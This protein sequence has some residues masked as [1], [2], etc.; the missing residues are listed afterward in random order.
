MSERGVAAVPWVLSADDEGGL[1]AAARA[2]RDHVAARAELEPADVGW[3]LACARERLA[4]RAV[5]VGADRETLL[6]GLDA[7]ARGAPTRNVARGTAGPADRVAFVFPGQGSQ[8]PGMALDLWAAAPAFGESMRACEAALAPYV[9][10]RLEDVLRAP[11]GAPLW[12]RS[13]VVQPAL[14][15]VMVSLAAL[16]RS[17]GVRPAAVVGHSLGEISAACAAGI[18]SVQDAARVAALTSRALHELGGDDGM[19][20]VDLA[21]EPLRERIAQIGGRLTPAAFNGP[22]A[23]VVAG[24]PGALDRLLAECDADGV[25]ARRIRVDGASSAAHTSRIEAIRERLADELA[26]IA[27]RPSGIAF[28]SAV[29]GEPIDYAELGPEYWYRSLRQPVRFREATSAAVRD[30]VTTFVEASPHPVL[31]LAVEGTIEAA[32]PAGDDR[33]VA[34]TGS[35][36]R[37]GGLERFLGSLGEAYAGGVDV[38]WAPAFA[39]AQPRRVQLPALPARAD[40][41]PAAAGAAATT[42]GRGAAGDALAGPRAA[43]RGALLALVREHAAAVL[44]LD[45]PAAV[46]PRRAFRELGMESLQAVELRNRL[47]QVTGL[48]LASTLAY[49]HPTPAAVAERLAALLSGEERAARATVPAQ[50]HHDEPIALVGM[51]CR[52]PRGVESAQDLW[53]L[54]AAGADAIGPFPTDR[55]WDLERLYDPD[56]DAPGTSYV[57]AGGF[58]YDAP[59]FDAAFFEIAPREALVMDPQQRLV[60][61]TAWAALEDAA[62]DPQRLAGSQTGV[63]IGIS[64]QDYASILPG[65]AP[66]YEGLRMTGALTSVVSGRVSYALGLQGPGVTVDTACSSSLVALHLACQALRSGECSLALAGGVTVL[67]SPG[68]FVEFSRQ[69]GLAPDGRSKAF[70][71]AADGASWAEGAGVLVVER[72][73]D[74]RRHGRRVLG[75]VR[76][77]ATN[78][79]GASNGLSAPNGPSQEQVIRQALANADLAPAEVDA[80]EAH[81]TGTTLGDPIEAGAL[82]ATYGQGRSDGPLRLGSIK[83]NIGHSHAAAGVAG[84]IKMAMAMRAGVLPRTLHVDA[85]TPHVDWSAGEI[86]LLTEALPWPRAGRARRAGVSGFGISGTNAHVVLEEAPEEEPAAGEPRAAPAVPWVLSAKSGGALR[87]QARRLREHLADRPQ[88]APLDVGWTLAAGRARLAHRAAIAGADRA[89][90]LAGLEAVARGLPADAVATGAAREPAKVAFVFPGQGSQWLGMALELWGSSDVFAA[91]MQACADALRPHVGWELRDV[92]AGAPG[93]PALERMDVVQPASFAVFVSLAALWR[94]LGVEPAVVVGH[95]QGEI[96]AAHVAGALSLDDAARVAALRSRAL[97]QLAGSGG[98]LSVFLPAEEVLERIARW[99]GRLS[100]ASYNGPRST[101]VSGEP[102]ALRELLA[103]CDAAGERARLI[104]VDYASHSVQIEAIR[105]RLLDDLRPIA[106]LRAEVPIVST[107][108]AAP[109]DGERLDAEHWY[110]NLREPVRF[111]QATRA[112]VQDGVTAFVESSPHPV[113]TWAVQET[114]DDAAPEPDRVAVVGTLRRGEGTLAR[115]LASAGE[116][117]VHGVEVDWEAAFAGR[118]PRRVGLPTYPFQRTRFWLEQRAP[119][120]GGSDSLTAAGLGAAEHP[121]L[122]AA[123]EL[124]ERDVRL[125]T[126]RLALDGQPGLADHEL[127]DELQLSP[128]AFAE[129]ALRAAAEAGCDALDELALAAPLVVAAQGA[130]QLQATVG[131]AGADGRRTIEI[132][133]RPGEDGAGWVRHAA[134]T[135]AAAPPATGGAAVDDPGAWPPAGAEPLDVDELYDRLAGRGAAYGPAFQTVRAAWR[136]GDELI[137]EVALG[138]QQAPDAARFAIHPALL[139][140]ALHPALAQHD[141]DGLATAASWRGLRVRRRGAA[142]LRVRI[143]RSGDAT[144]R[145]TATD[146][147]GQPVLAVDEVVLRPL[148]GARRGGALE[149]LY[150]VRWSPAQAPSSNG[151]P[152]RLSVLGDAGASAGGADAAGGARFEQL[153]AFAASEP[154]P[155]SV[156]VAAPADVPAALELLQGWVADERLHDARLAVLVP[157]AAAVLDGEAPDP[158]AAAIRGLVRSAQSEHPGRIVSIDAGAAADVGPA[159][160]TGEAEVAVRDGAVFVPRLARAPADTPPPAGSWRLAPERAGALGGATPAEG[161][162]DRPLR[163]GEVRLAIR[164]AGVSFRDVLVAIGVHGAA[165]G[166]EAA[167]VVNEVA[168]D[169]RALAPGDRGMGLVPGA[170]GPLAVADARMLVPIPAG[171]AFAQ[172]ATV[173]LAHAAAQLALVEVARLA[174]GERVLVHAA[175]GG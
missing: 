10:W 97:V 153:A 4:R 158:R 88:L 129:I 126:G 109:V 80:V 155:G 159:L 83:S 7:V 101:V 42:A 21:A 37:G 77:T 66:E 140:G 87:A 118:R 107:T 74:A 2:L 115:F 57:R 13:D 82:L 131:A 168:S 39:A 62:I 58:V 170:F 142:A 69:R 146:E 33:V 100:L 138:E 29:T 73:S 157:G 63:Y 119:A 92:L 124:A 17:F 31:T 151:T 46:A 78:Q 23:I 55:G 133:A 162:G 89:A 76:G 19:V 94:S 38:D 165:L 137:A 30:G 166:I 9:D 48:R 98:M 1:R 59:D 125:L 61:E 18:L 172:A 139:D 174:P 104:A 93:A 68:M 47:A 64:S 81:G 161:D 16:W 102:Q 144:L 154:P 123:V 116:A 167:G 41:A 26:P 147:R 86:E 135:I 51:S 24:E 99:D 52:Y 32:L 45:S 53:E 112:L 90:L 44:G 152:L 14:F 12:E 160:A 110:R 127:L 175:A 28:Y 145:L 96:A 65:V 36:R 5:V 163:R 91:R 128:A 8:W 60:L 43:D 84:V 171:W 122:G 25:G 49:D 143:A 71:A 117:W 132:H 3:S 95:S 67:S 72:L 114:V 120:A 22:R 70:A 149:A 20:L 79:D 108:T 169:V 113:L 27:P 56:P 136:S 134:G 75:L 111:E 11:P 173:P 15:C 156:L 34:V 103:E 106:P 105:E 121:L 40:A 164:A 141:A 35:L 85:P 54:V 148:A 150:R 6:A 130:V 50:A